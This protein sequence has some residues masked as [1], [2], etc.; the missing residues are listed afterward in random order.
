M[1]NW[2][3][4][5]GDDGKPYLEIDNVT[6]AI[7]RTY[8]SD[9]EVPKA[10]IAVSPPGGAANL[11][12]GPKAPAWLQNMIEST[13][14]AVTEAAKLAAIP[15]AMIGSMPPQQGA[16]GYDMA[17]V[18]AL[19]AGRWN[20]RASYSAWTEANPS[21]PRQGGK[22]ALAAA[23][24]DA[25]RAVQ[26]DE[27]QEFNEVVNMQGDVVRRDPVDATDEPVVGNELFDAFKVAR[28]A[29]ANFGL[30]PGC[31][32]PNPLL[33]GSPPAGTV[34]QR[35]PGDP[36]RDTSRWTLTPPGGVASAGRLE[37]AKVP[38]Q[39]GTISG[40]PFIGSPNVPA[41]S[42][43]IGNPGGMF[44]LP[45]DKSMPTPEPEPAPPAGRFQN[46]DW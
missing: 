33:P 32:W 36:L 27:A 40:F 46:L 23:R 10:F 22:A 30:D 37:S 8:P 25:L 26:S 16:R 9:G 34:Q 21:Y 11:P 38:G 6:F 5:T 28:D 7:P 41:G 43:L 42:W 3:V 39:I 15:P 19:A 44:G 45:A 4:M 24:G 20:E 17:A 35:L 18:Q 31:D 29:M 14:Q 2:R 13:T 12:V 1:S